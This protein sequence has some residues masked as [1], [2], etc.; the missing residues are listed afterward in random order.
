VWGDEKR[1]KVNNRCS[2]SGQAV[3]QAVF[4]AVARGAGTGHTRTSS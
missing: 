1:E 3:F 2:N 4:Q